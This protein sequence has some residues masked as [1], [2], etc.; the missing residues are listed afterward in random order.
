MTAHP[1]CQLYP[2]LSDVWNYTLPD[3]LLPSLF[4]VR[5]EFTLCMNELEMRATQPSVFHR[6]YRCQVYRPDDCAT[7]DVNYIDS[8]LTDHMFLNTNYHYQFYLSIWVTKNQWIGRSI[9]V[10]TNGRSVCIIET[11]CEKREILRWIDMEILK[12]CGSTHSLH[13]TESFSLELPV[14]E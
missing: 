14:S 6:Q 5:T 4:S 9:R 2:Q 8:P 13:W 3:W 12:H 7:L 10:N 11:K 1:L